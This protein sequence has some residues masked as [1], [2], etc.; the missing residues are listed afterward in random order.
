MF[1]LLICCEPRKDEGEAKLFS[2]EKILT[3]DTENDQIAEMGLTDISFFD[4]DSEGKIFVA[5]PKAKENYI[6]MLNCDGS[7]ISVFGREEQ[8]PGELQSQLERSQNLM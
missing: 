4:V 5:N 7:L 2:L 6:F 8:G 3:V 1:C